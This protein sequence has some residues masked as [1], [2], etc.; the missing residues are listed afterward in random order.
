M[1][2]VGLTGGI[3]SGKST[4]SNHLREMGVPVFD[5]DR[6]AHTAVEKGSPG[7][8]KAVKIFGPRCLLPN[9][10]LNRVWVADQVF[11]NEDLMAAYGGMV[12]DEVR[13]RAFDF[14]GRMQHSD[15]T[16]SVLDVPLLIECGW[17][18]FVDLVWLVAV[19]PEE[20]VRRTMLRDHATE[21]QVRARIAA[22]M[23]LEEKKKYADLII[24][25]SKTPENTCRQVNNAVSRLEKLAAEAKKARASQ[26]IIIAK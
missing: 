3:G 26:K 19:D 25:N 5:A 7:L 21:E 16:M 23:S 15:N 9:G 22:Q 12:Q 24:D 14:M 13:R 1:K 2:V 18:E 8:D 11:H 10:E 4:V 6:E 20:Q 17:H